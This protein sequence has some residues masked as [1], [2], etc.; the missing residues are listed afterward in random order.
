[1]TDATNWNVS[2]INGTQ[3]LVIDTAA[4]RIPLDFDPSSSMFIAVAAPNGGLGNI[5]ALVKGETGDTPTFDETINLTVLD[6]D[7]PT[8]D[9]ATLTDLGGNVYQA[10]L[11]IHS[12]E[13]G[14]AGTSVLDPQAYGTPLAGYLL[15]VNSTADDFVYRP[16]LVGDRYLP[17][18]INST[19][20]GNPLYTLA[21]VSVPAQSF[22]W[23]P[24][25]SGQAV[26]TGT[27][28]RNVTVNLLARLNSETAGNIV[29]YGFG[30]SGTPGLPITLSS[31]PPAGSGDAYDKVTAGSAAVIYLRA[32]RSTGTDTFTT[33]SSTT[34]FAVR[35][36]PIPGTGTIST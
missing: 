2:T 22:D 14:V 25:V 33:S 12:G 34:T 29:G 8:A 31:G 16:Q 26:V 27:G 5:P 4:F 28:G 24:V 15:V 10:N 11:T 1:M 21:A 20:A 17:A 13:P 19:P 30:A 35:V 3:Y 36:A 18:S 23:R 32:E 7:D 6:Y 9:S